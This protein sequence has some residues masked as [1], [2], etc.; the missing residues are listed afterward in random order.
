[1]RSFSKRVGSA[2]AIVSV[3][4]SALLLLP[5][6]AAFG[7]ALPDAAEEPMTILDVGCSVSTCIEASL[8]AG[9][10]GYVRARFEHSFCRFTRSHIHL[11]GPGHNF[12]TVDNRH[13]DG[14]WTVWYGPYNRGTYCVE[15]WV[16]AGTT[17]RPV[18]LPCKTI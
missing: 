18:G 9:G 10:Y 4:S 14:Q 7:A 16:F 17:W 12:D 2:I 8:T 13:C 6:S 5:T 3:I 1:M 11:W 15:G